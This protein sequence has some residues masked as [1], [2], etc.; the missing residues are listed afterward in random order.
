MNLG[1]RRLPE[2]RSINQELELDLKP[3]NRNKNAERR[4]LSHAEKGRII[5]ITFPLLGFEESNEIFYC[6]MKPKPA[7]K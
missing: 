7:G 1:S 5:I 4:I 6:M 2:A 3:G